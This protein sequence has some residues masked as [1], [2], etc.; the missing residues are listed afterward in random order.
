MWRSKKSINQN[1]ENAELKKNNA[2]ESKKFS[3]S[4]TGRG[5]GVT[6]KLGNGL[7]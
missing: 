4:C 1:D 2:S 7:V 5:V 3:P 6:Q